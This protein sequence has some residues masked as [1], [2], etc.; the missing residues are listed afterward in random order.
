MLC[1]SNAEKLA[2]HIDDD[3]MM[4]VETVELEFV[5]ST[6]SVPMQKEDV[7]KKSDPSFLSDQPADKKKMK[8]IHK[9]SEFL[10]S[11]IDCAELKKFKLL[12]I[13]QCSKQRIQSQ[14]NRKQVL[15][16]LAILDTI[17]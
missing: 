2:L 4:V 11:F 12:K 1:N 3:M 14:I 7:L 5:V 10:F 9:F 6:S 15:H 16:I 8:I 13:Q 17:V